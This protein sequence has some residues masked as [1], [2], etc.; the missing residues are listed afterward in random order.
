MGQFLRN[1]KTIHLIPGL[2][3][4]GN[5]NEFAEALSLSL[6]FVR[7]KHDIFYN[8]YGYALQHA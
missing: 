1:S 6:R 3:T 4:T 8:N 7:I 2:Q 5:K